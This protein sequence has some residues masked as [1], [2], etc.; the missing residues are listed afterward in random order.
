V[1]PTPYG[2]LRRTRRS[3]NDDLGAQ[4]GGKR[5]K[6]DTGGGYVRVSSEAYPRDYPDPRLVPHSGVATPTDPRRAQ[7][8]FGREGTATSGTV[9]NSDKRGSGSL[10]SGTER[11]RDSP[12]DRRTVGREEDEEEF[13]S[14]PRRL[15]TTPTTA[16]RPS[17]VG[18]GHT[19]TVSRAASSLE[20]RAG[21]IAA[22]DD[23]DADADGSPDLTVA[24]G[25][26]AHKELMELAEDDSEAMSARPGM[27]RTRSDAPRNGSRSSMNS[28]DI[29]EMIAQAAGDED[30]PSNARYGTDASMRTTTKRHRATG[31]TLSRNPGGSISTFPIQ[32]GAHLDGHSRLYPTATQQSQPKYMSSGSPVAPPGNSRPY[33]FRNT[34]SA[35]M[36]AQN[37]ARSSEESMQRSSFSGAL[38]TNVARSP[39]V[40]TPGPMMTM[41]FLPPQSGPPMPKKIYHHKDTGQVIGSQHVGLA[42]ALNGPADPNSAAQRSAIAA[43]YLTSDGQRK[44]TCRQCGQP[45][46]YKENKCVE[47]WG[48]GPDGPGTVCDRCRKKMKRVEKR[49]TQDSAMMAANHHHQYPIAPAPAASFPQ[50]PLQVSLHSSLRPVLMSILRVRSGSM[51]RKSQVTLKLQMMGD[52]CCHVQAHKIILHYINPSL[53]VAETMHQTRQC[54][55]NLRTHTQLSIHRVRQCLRL[56]LS[57]MRTRLPHLVEAIVA[58]LSQLQTSHLMVGVVMMTQTATLTWTS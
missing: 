29:E 1:P 44:R 13:P 31:S 30:D 58:R 3:S 23:G 45:G 16:T 17:V 35:D 47:K 28:Q 38:P 48:P 41:Q 39:S 55:E 20:A 12:S 19:S 14:P 2:S 33:V 26:G 8:P 7:P 25:L 40:P 22:G 49:A 6:T 27:K 9:A 42:P 56:L 5:L 15:L 51:N 10:G 54:A 57:L 4:A 43:V 53:V 52:L 36:E 50:L 37:Q 46:R 34:D 18:N 24:A 11:G 32:F 21:P